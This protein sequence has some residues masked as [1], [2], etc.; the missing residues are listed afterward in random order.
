MEH[1]AGV[2]VPGDGGGRVAK[3]RLTRRQVM[4]RA[5]AVATA[6]AVAWV[7]PEILIAQPGS[8]AGLSG[9][10]GGNVS[11]GAGASVSTPVG[12]ASAG[13]GVSTSASTA[14]S[15]GAADADARVKGHASVDPGGD[16]SSHKTRADAGIDL[17]HDGEVGSALMASGWDL[18][19]W[20]PNRG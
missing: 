12:G 2:E 16:P 18:R 7:V 13:A 3:Q 8:A 6:G 14:D 10:P 1:S 15:A 17:D 4:G 11:G 9:N 5:G 20:S 19:R